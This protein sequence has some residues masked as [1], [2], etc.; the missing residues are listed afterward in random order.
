MR[1]G[2]CMRPRC[3]WRRVGQQA[4][5][6]VVTQRGRIQRVVPIDQ[7]PC[8]SACVHRFTDAPACGPGMVRQGWGTPC[9]S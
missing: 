2:V 3:R 7:E 5:G 9:T 8:D 1:G 6:V 4:Q